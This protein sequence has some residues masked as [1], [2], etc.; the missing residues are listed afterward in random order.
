VGSSFIFRKAVPIGLLI[1]TGLYTLFFATVWVLHEKILFSGRTAEITQTPESLRWPYE[2]VWA[3]VSGGKTHGWWLPLEKAK[4]MVLF[5]HGRGENISHYLNDAAYFRDSGFSVLLYDY[6]GYGQST[7]SPSENRCYADIRAMWQY[8]VWTRGIPEDRIVLAGCSMGGGPTADLAANVKPGAV[9]LESSFISI[10]DAAADTYWW[11]PIFAMTRTQFRNIDKV[12][13]IQCPVLV[14]HSR[15]DTVV[16][17]EHGRRLY[18]AIRTPKQFVEIR[19]SH[20]GCKSSSK[21]IYDPALKQ[22]LDEHFKAGG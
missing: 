21:D 2:E 13:R 1:A 18:E 9:I 11:L 5:S 8:L 6:G 7:G 19:G 10:P 22:F 16:P 14:V 20:S 4:G 3:D 12:P 15:D 17:F